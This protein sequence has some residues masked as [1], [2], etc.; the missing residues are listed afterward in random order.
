MTES[1]ASRP[2]APFTV[3]YRTATGDGG[4][5]CHACPF[6]R[7]G[8]F[9][10]YSDAFAVAA[11]HLNVCRGAV[12]HRPVEGD[13]ILDGDMHTVVLREGIMVLAVDAVFRAAPAPLRLVF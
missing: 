6:Q 9:P 12:R 4:F 13:A 1:I 11:Q 7:N 3:F 8:T 10:R 2:T 5:I